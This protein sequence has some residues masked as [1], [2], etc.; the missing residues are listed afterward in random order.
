MLYVRMSHHSHK[1]NVCEANVRTNL[2]AWA[3][4]AG[5]GL[6][7]QSGVI[8]R[9]RITIACLP[10]AMCGVVD[11]LKII[12][13]CGIDSVCIFAMY[14]RFIATAYHAPS[15]PTHWDISFPFNWS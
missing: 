7:I 11:N 3:Y 1:A 5:N 4:I 13:V 9:H 8:S 10:I 15:C 2:K 14:L 12:Y 6:N